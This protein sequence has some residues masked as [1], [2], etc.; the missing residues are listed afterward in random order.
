M[1]PSKERLLAAAGETAFDAR[2]LERVYRLVD[3]LEGMREHSYLKGRWVLKGGTALNLFL[4]D[5][6]RLSVDIDVNYIGSAERE[7]MLSERPTLEKALQAVFGRHGLTVRRAAAAD[8]H[9]GGKWSL[10]YESV[11]GQ[12]GNLEIDLNYL[13]RIPLWPPT[14]MTSQKLGGVQVDGIPVLDLHE[15]A[16]GKLAALLSRHA[17]RDLFDAHRLLGDQRVDRERLR[18]A[19][20]LYGAMSR[21][22]WRTVQESDADFDL[23][24]LRDQLIPLLRNGG[25]EVTK[26]PDAWAKTLLEECR[27]RLKAILPLSAQEKKFL[28]GILDR[29][30]VDPALLTADT[31]LADRILA[32]PGL[33]WKALN[34]RQFKGKKR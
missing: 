11:L 1:I 25:K 20:V 3:L 30:E 21:K 9:A 10:R 26:S 34:V 8:E 15:L 23:R 12:G 27:E 7:V 19:F 16:A 31:A 14:A 28:D 22:D 17:A 5:V 33:Q 32:H 24:E 13:L 6:P 4:F 29:G 2:S 18:T